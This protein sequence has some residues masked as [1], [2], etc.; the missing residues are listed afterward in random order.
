MR[1]IEC[2]AIAKLID[3][4]FHIRAISVRKSLPLCTSL[5]RFHTTTADIYFEIVMENKLTAREGAE[6]CEKHPVRRAEKHP[7]LNVVE[8]GL[9]PWQSEPQKTGQQ[10]ERYGLQPV[11]T[12]EHSGPRLLEIPLR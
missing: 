1:K 12:R 5:Y 8:R 11:E 10:T 6:V 2:N 9:S 7:A 4:F 3:L